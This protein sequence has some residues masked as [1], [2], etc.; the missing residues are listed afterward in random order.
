LQDV[1]LAKYLIV[2]LCSRLTLYDSCP[3]MKRNSWFTKDL[4]QHFAG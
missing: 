2:L 4:Q 3:A 1:I